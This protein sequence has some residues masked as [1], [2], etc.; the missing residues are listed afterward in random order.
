MHSQPFRF[1]YIITSSV[2]ISTHAPKEVNGAGGFEPLK[3]FS[4]KLVL[5]TDTETDRETETEKG[6]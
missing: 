4:I 1:Q 3:L 6:R 2:P 5:L